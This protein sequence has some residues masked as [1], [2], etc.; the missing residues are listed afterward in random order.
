[1]TAS[2][3]VLTSQISISLNFF[4]TSYW[5]LLASGSTGSI[6]LFGLDSLTIPSAN[7]TGSF[8]F[9]SSAATFADAQLAG[10]L[11]FAAADQST[12]VTVGLFQVSAL[13]MSLNA[14]GTFTGS[15]TLGMG[16]VGNLAITIAY[17]SATDYT[18]TVS[19]GSLN[20][21]SGLSVSNVTGTVSSGQP[22]SGSGNINIGGCPL[23]VNLGFTSSSVWS[24]SAAGSCSFFN[25][26]TSFTASGNISQSTGQSSPV[27][28][29]TFA[30]N[31][32]SFYGLTLSN[33]SMTYTVSA[34]GGSFI[35]LGTLAIGGGS[36]AATITYTD[37]NNWS[38]SVA[39][40]ATGSL[41]VAPGVVITAVSGT[42]V[43]NGSLTLSFAGTLAIG[44]A[45]VTLTANYQ[46]RDTW[47]LAASGQISAFGITASVSG[48]LSD[49]A[50]TL[51]STIQANLNPVTFDGITMS[52]I[53]VRWTT[54][55]DAGGNHLVGTATISLGT[56][57][58]LNL[59]ISYQDANDWTLTAAGAS[60][61]LNIIPGFLALP[62]ASY[63]GSITK[64]RGSGTRPATYAYSIAV[65]LGQTTLIPSAVSTSSTPILTTTVTF[66]Y[67]TAAPTYGGKPV[68][69]SGTNVSYLS[70]SGTATLN[71]GATLGTASVNWYAAYGMQSG[72]FV[73]I[74]DLA[75]SLTIPGT[76]MISL[77][78]PKLVVSYGTGSKA[79]SAGSAVTL[80]TGSGS[81]SGFSIALSGIV[82]LSSPLPSASIPVT[83]TYQNGGFI[84]A[85][86]FG[87]SG[88]SI[89]SLGASLQT[90]AYT[91]VV[92]TMTLSG[93]SVTV[94]AN[95][96]VFGGTLTM[97][98]WVT[99]LMGVSMAPIG[100]NLVY[101]TP[102]NFSLEAVIP[103]A[104]PI[105]TGSSSYSF[106]FTSFR[107]KISNTG[108]NLTQGISM[109]GQFIVQGGPTIGVLASLSF[110]AASS[111]LTGSFTAANADGSP[112]WPNALGFRGFNIISFTIQVGIQLAAVPFPLPTL[113]LQA[114]AELPNNILAPLGITTTGLGISAI[115]NISE[116][117]PCI[118][119]ALGS[120]G[121]N[122]TVIDAGSAHPVIN[123]QNVVTASYAHFVLA[124]TG[125]VVGPYTV[126]PG[127]AIDFNGTF[128]S[129]PVTFNMAITPE[130]FAFSA[131]ASIGAFSAGPVN[132]SGATVSM[133]YD[134]STGAGSASFAGSI[135]I[136]GTT[137]DL[138]GSASV[139]GRG[140]RSMSLTGSLS[141]INFGG[142]SL[143]N[144]TFGGNYSSA[145]NSFT[146]SATGKLNILGSV[147][148]V[149][150]FQ[151][152]YTA[153]IVT[154]VHVDISTS[155]NIANVVAISGDF[156]LDLN[157]L[158]G[159][160]S[161]SVT[162][163]TATIQ[164]FGLT[165]V[166]L[167]AD[168]RSGFSFSGQVNVANVVTATLSGQMYWAEPSQSTQITDSNGNQVT[169]HSGDFYFS[170]NPVT[171]TIG[172]FSTQGRVTIGHVGS[173]GWASFA[174][175][176]SLDNHGSNAI[177]VA[178]SFWSGGNYS[179]TGSGVLNLGGFRINVS[180]AASNM[181]GTASVTA[182]G[183]INVQGLSATLAGSFSKSGGGVSTTMSASLNVNIGGFNFGNGT[184]T[185]SITPQSESFALSVGVNAGPFSGTLAG[186]FVNANG[187]V[188]FYFNVNMGINIPGVSVGGSL[189]VT[190]CTNSGCGTISNFS[191]SLAGS[192][193]VSGR[194]FS[195]SVPVNPNFSFSVSSSGSFSG[196]TGEQN[197]GGLKLNASLSGS[198]TASLSSSSPY[199]SFSTNMQA[200]INIGTWY[201][202]THCDSGWVWVHC[203][204]DSGYNWSSTSIG[205]S[206][207][208]S[209][210]VS[211]NWNG[212][213]F[214]L[215]L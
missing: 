186:T 202:N 75:S 203:H 143:T 4:S 24:V 82:V 93:I 188:G 109:S 134:S 103:M 70:A 106:S 55:T 44:D 189:T 32:Q 90:L 159:T 198:Y 52:N 153:G 85:A 200:S 73:L 204:T 37:S 12:P 107:F 214:S 183:A 51:S 77:A 179:L 185:M 68:V 195:F 206:M 157:T 9:G 88:L 145:T 79:P 180:V 199:V 201:L 3:S 46:A 56:S 92:T 81:T 172:S 8:T 192:F 128:M 114:T 133:A 26:T 35:A 209:G 5:T 39:S 207:D 197:W 105:P 63:T 136:V 193:S 182:S 135:T 170:A 174:V 163:G 117:N 160:A 142:F 36:L 43:F 164:G 150:Q 66:N 29:V 210:N 61:Q 191:V 18:F 21:F 11:I 34:T 113:G 50:G 6:K 126:A 54:G 19:S 130:P 84:I 158:A 167:Q 165:N 139:D 83:L 154:Q 71:L 38:I 122:G 95:S 144:L 213:G 86:S 42:S 146:L 97:P 140:N 104:I 98:T 111:T 161:L 94:P 62:A 147:L 45:T 16:S 48:N 211:G 101:T 87:S 76:T 27:G 118:D 121:P 30:M 99:N 208:S 129:V 141:A 78:S 115:L 1:M 171:I 120:M 96:L 59:S 194:N 91:N 148:D 22:F 215:H 112:V 47:S 53:A 187:T 20:I 119:V 205:V 80:P 212:W 15:A 138:A 162:N 72:S 149:R 25:L 169:A 49:S 124:P 155:I 67:G 58:T 181:N 65:A 60:G 33:L 131:S 137:L 184:M 23:T 132:F 10:S 125:C 17:R 74:G 28:S 152:T 100:L 110:A 64:T 168:A 178:G 31:S 69:I 173:V 2:L 14:D 123:I 116:A 166:N 57:V 156:V 89:A 108:S 102:T 175:A 40:D 127:F 190:N 151:V 41:T 176:I 196:G 7:V 13:T 177:N